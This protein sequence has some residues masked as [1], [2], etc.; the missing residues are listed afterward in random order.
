MSLPSTR[1]YEEFHAKKRSLSATELVDKSIRETQA[2][3]DDTFARLAERGHE[4]EGNEAEQYSAM[5]HR[6]RALE[7]AQ[8][9][10]NL[11]GLTA[12]AIKIG[13]KRR[14]KPVLLR[15]EHHP[16]DQQQQAA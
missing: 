2:L 4:I 9:R 14:L 3:E 13:L 11:Q 12:K 16:T 5:V 7:R 10:N 6:L 15:L 1:D 8:G